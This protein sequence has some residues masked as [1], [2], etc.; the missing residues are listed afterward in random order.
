[1]VTLSLWCVTDCWFRNSAYLSM[2]PHCHQHRH[3]ESNWGLGFQSLPLG[4]SFLI[5]CLEW[6]DLALHH[7]AAY[8]AKKL[9]AFYCPGFVGF[10]VCPLPWQLIELQILP[11]VSWRPASRMKCCSL[12][13]SRSISSPV[14]DWAIRDSSNISQYCS[15][16]WTNHVKC[17]CIVQ[18][19]LDFVVAKRIPREVLKESVLY[20]S[21]LIGR[22]A[23]I[24]L[25]LLHPQELDLLRRE[26]E[27]TVPFVFEK[28]VYLLLVRAVEFANYTCRL[29]HVM[30]TPWQDVASQPLH[31][32][33][34]HREIFFVD[35]TKHVEQFRAEHSE[36][37][38]VVGYPVEQFLE[39]QE[40]QV[41][42][43]CMYLGNCNWKRIHPT[44]VGLGWRFGIFCTRSPS[45]CEN[46]TNANFS[47]ATFPV[48]GSC[49]GKLAYENLCLH[50]HLSNPLWENLSAIS[51]GMCTPPDSRE[52]TQKS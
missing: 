19:I 7:F 36:R 28:I 12:C 18:H 29:H 47:N 42:L 40:L 25:M 48:A 5:S 4:A 31:I 49:K 15:V 3:L 35:E 52:L 44:W 46:V 33:E 11:S 22:L 16:S 21:R 20:V 9:Q 39:V 38:V 45:A 14:A 24:F 32:D 13:R 30:P 1:M 43:G 10:Q 6:Q 41:T 2:C 23:S 51:C 34:Q 17:W 37:L 8:L 26:I 50:R 27:M